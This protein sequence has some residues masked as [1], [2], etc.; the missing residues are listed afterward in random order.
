MQFRVFRINQ[1]RG[2]TFLVGTHSP[3]TSKLRDQIGAVLAGAWSG[4]FEG[5]NR[6][7]ANYGFELVF[8]R[9]PPTGETELPT[10][11]PG[12]F[13]MVFVLLESE[14]G[15][16]VGESETVTGI[17]RA[18]EHSLQGLKSKPRIGL[19]TLYNCSVQVL[20]SKGV[21][22]AT[23]TP[24]IHPNPFETPS[25]GYRGKRVSDDWD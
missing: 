3:P 2:Y 11:E 24:T 18:I 8:D 6:N 25:R 5:E 10:L 22:L 17:L 7:S 14:S 15:S 4:L 21:T 9:T 12:K 1:E 16:A 19:V 13:Y 23:V 20:E